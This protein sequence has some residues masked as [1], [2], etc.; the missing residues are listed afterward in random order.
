MPTNPAIYLYPPLLRYGPFADGWVER[1]RTRADAET[2]RAQSFRMHDGIFGGKDPYAI[3]W[4]EDHGADLLI[5]DAAGNPLTDILRMLIR[6]TIATAMRADA[7]HKEMAGIL[8]S[9]YA[10][11]PNAAQIIATTEIGLANG[12]GGLAGA[13]AVG[14][15]AKRWLVSNDPG[16]CDGCSANAAQGW[17]SIDTPYASGALAPLDHAGCRCDAAYRRKLP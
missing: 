17:I 16:V 2:A 13:I 7:S 5:V 6:Q 10:F 8:R 15:K 4:A 3:A 11:S 14:A 1:I 9:M 12:Y